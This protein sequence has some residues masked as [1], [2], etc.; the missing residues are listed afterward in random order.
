[1]TARGSNGHRPGPPPRTTDW[2]AF[3]YRPAD[4]TP[5]LACARCGGR[6]FDDTEGHHA[7]HVVF[8]HQPRQP[9]GTSR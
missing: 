6:Y 9:K 5:L 3:A 2:A 1:M 4:S 7:H 8:G